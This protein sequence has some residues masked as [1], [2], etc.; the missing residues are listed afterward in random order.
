MAT[1]VDEAM[2][3]I[4][5]Y[6]PTFFPKV[7][8]I[9][10]S[11]LSAISE[12]LTNPITIPFQAFGLSSG[13][14]AGHASL[15]I[16]GYLQDTPVV[17]L[18]GRIHLYEG[19]PYESLRTLIRVVKHL[20]TN[21][22]IISGAVGSLHDDVGPGEVVAISDH[23][24]FQPGNPLVGPNDESIG[25]RFVSMEDAYNA[26]LRATLIQT[27]ERLNI[28]V[29]EGVYLS[30]LG[31]SFET[32][33]EIRA[34][35]TL[36]AD[37]IGMSVVPETILARHAGLKVVGVGAVTNFASGISADKVTHEQTLHY[38]ELTARKLVKLIP[39]FLK[40]AE[41]QFNA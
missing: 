16:L 32:P 23:I 12:Q 34:F 31:P 14:V 36:G 24:N 3:V 21:T 5:K 33:A 39:A 6:A 37:I 2:S 7:G 29:S 19:A 17:C 28:T 41:P 22:L 27:G 10:G 15:M 13:T 26:D 40:D 30:V 1:A 9:L 11:G 25:P 8:M 18:K 20:G 38:G 35:R 4:R